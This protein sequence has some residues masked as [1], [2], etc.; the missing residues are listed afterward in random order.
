MK[1]QN[2]DKYFTSW[3]EGETGY[4]KV[5]PITINITQDA[6]KLEQLAKKAAEEIAAEVSYAWDLGKTD[7]DA[8]WLTWGGYSLEEEIPYFAAI[9]MPEAIDKLNSFDPEDNDY[10]CSTVEEFRDLLFNAYDEELKKSDLTRGFQ[11][12]IASLDAKVLKTLHY[13]LESWTTR[14]KD[15]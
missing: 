9:S 5:A 14:A 7:S 4:F 3:N 2:F 8:W 15:L 11:L 6:A 12:W 10:E 1:N 13:D